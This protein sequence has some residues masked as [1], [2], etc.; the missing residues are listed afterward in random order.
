MHCYYQTRHL[1]IDISVQTMLCLSA[2][3]VGFL[4][5]SS[6]WNEL[7]SNKTIA[8]N[9][10]DVFF[11]ISVRKTLLSTLLV[12][13]DKKLCIISQ[14][15]LFFFTAYAWPSKFIDVR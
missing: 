15:K 14:L 12:N 7:R 10:C 1:R 5:L 8:R 13:D 11:F 9:I 4:F 2:Q 6:V 3:N